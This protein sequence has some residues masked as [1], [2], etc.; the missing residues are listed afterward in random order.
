MANFPEREE[1]ERLLREA[2]GCNPGPWGG[3]SRVAA[4]CAERIANA[5]GMEPEK[6]Y[7]LG[8]LHDIGRKFGIK[9]LAHVYDGYRYMMELGYDAAARI[10]LTHSFC[11]PTLEV[12]IGRFDIPEEQQEELQRLLNALEFDDYDRLI[13][14]C[15]CLAGVEGVV[16]MEE[17]MLDVKRRYGFYRQDKWDTNMELKRYFEEKCG[18]DIYEVCNDPV[19]KDHERSF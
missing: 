18:R 4:R 1:A 11:R 15:D 16:D 7:V 13:Q 17:R 12:Y 6:A 9:H 10:C 14:L 2:E 5:A 3:H 8:L 19:L